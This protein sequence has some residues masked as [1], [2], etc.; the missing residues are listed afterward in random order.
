VVVVWLA[1]SRHAAYNVS[2]L[3]STSH[4]VTVTWFPAYD[5]GHHIHYVLW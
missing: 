1:S 2:V 5:A 4:A 3:E